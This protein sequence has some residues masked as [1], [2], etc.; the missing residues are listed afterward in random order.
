M[1][2]LFREAAELLKA[3]DGGAELTDDELKLIN[4]ATI[5]LMINTG[6]FFP[7]DITMAEG[8]EALAGIVEE[9]KR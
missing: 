2:N 9:V 7:K 4:T 5:P 3:K 8:L 1:T 6:G